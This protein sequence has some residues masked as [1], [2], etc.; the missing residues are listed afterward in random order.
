MAKFKFIYGP[1]TEFYDLHGKL[2]KKYK[3]IGAFQLYQ[4]STI[5]LP[6]PFYQII[7]QQKT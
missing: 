6:P 7:C 3:F 4:F 5:K 2:D 1:N